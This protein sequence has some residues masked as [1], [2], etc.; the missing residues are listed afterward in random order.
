MISF[1]LVCARGHGFDGWFGS[2]SDFDAQVAGGLLVCPVCGDASVTKAL[3]AP[4]VATA[5]TRERAVLEVHRSMVAARAAMESEAAPVAQ[6]DV[7]GAPAA[8]ARAASLK[9]MPEPVKAYVE[10][11]RKLRAAVEAG[12]ED[13]GARFAEEARRMHEGLVDERPIRGEASLA[14]AAA[15]HEDGIDVF[16]LP[17]LPEDGH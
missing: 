14:D 16:I 3:M 6:D 11:V 8:M 1:A 2:S 15:L 10:A 17:P 13:V 7:K 5:R 12:A 9:D 4:N